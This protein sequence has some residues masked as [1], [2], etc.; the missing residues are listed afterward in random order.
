MYFTNKGIHKS[1][2]EFFVKEQ[3]NMQKLPNKSISLVFSTIGSALIGTSLM[4]KIILYIGNTSFGRN[5]PIFNM[6]IAYY[7]F[8]KPMLQKL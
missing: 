4:E 8:Q 7:M 6:D 5:D 1:L 3:I 2:K